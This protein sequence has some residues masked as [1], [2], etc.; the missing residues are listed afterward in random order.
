MQNYTKAIGATL[1]AL[2][3]WGGA[4]GI[5]QLANLNVDQITNLVIVIGSMIGT[6]I[7]PPNKVVP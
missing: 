7:A 6:Y 1:G 3:A 4:L 2:V 5:S